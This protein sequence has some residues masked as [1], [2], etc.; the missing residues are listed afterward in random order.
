MAAEASVWKEASLAATLSVS[1]SSAVAAVATFARSSLSDQ[2]LSAIAASLLTLCLE[3]TGNGRRR[4][5]RTLEPQRDGTMVRF[6]N[7]W[8]RGGIGRDARCPELSRRTSVQAF[9]ICT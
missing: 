8:F 4:R 3:G 2:N 7:E 9:A 1:S 5:F 6:W